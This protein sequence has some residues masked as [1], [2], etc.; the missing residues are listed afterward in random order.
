MGDGHPSHWESQYRYNN[1]QKKHYTMKGLMTIPVPHKRNQPTSSPWFAGPFLYFDDLSRNLTSHGVDD[2]KEQLQSPSVHRVQSRSSGNLRR[3][4]VSR[5]SQVHLPASS[6]AFK[7]W[8]EVVFQQ[9][10][11]ALWYV[12]TYNYIGTEDGGNIRYDHSTSG[13]NNNTFKKIDGFSH[14]H[15]PNKHEYFSNTWQ[16]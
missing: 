13:S 15:Q 2:A 16:I 8:G 5:I 3:Q 7:Q 10:D 12:Y 9:V 1:I 11:Q 14:Q 6:V 4:R